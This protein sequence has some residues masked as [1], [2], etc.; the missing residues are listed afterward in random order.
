MATAQTSKILVAVHGIGPQVGYETVQSVAMRIAAYYGTAPAV[1]LGHFYPSSAT[2]GALLKPMPRLMQAPN[3]PET[4]VGLGFAEVYWAGIAKEPEAAGYVL[5]EAKKWAR[6]ISARLTLRAGQTGNRLP[7]REQLRLV[8]VLDQIIDTI[9]IFERLSYLPA[10]AGFFEFGLRRLLVDFVGDVQIVADFEAYRQRILDE[11]DRVMTQASQLSPEGAATELY[12]VAHSEGSVVAFLAL[13]TALASPDRHPWI[14]KVRGMLTIGSPIETHHLLWPE[15]WQKTGPDFAGL[16]PHPLAPRGIRWHNHFDRGD[17]IAYPL[18]DTR[19]WLEAQGFRPHLQ[20]EET[21]FSRFLLPGKAHTD[22]WHDE[23]VFGHFI[24]TI[25]KLPPPKTGAVR[26]FK[27]PPKNKPGVVVVSY[28]I[29]YALIMALLVAATYVLYRPASDI[30]VKGGLSSWTVVRDVIGMG[31]L[32][33]GITA[34]GRLPRLMQQKRWWLISAALLAVSMVCYSNVTCASSRR[35]LGWA[36]AERDLLTS[37]AESDVAKRWLS[38]ET[39]FEACDADMNSKEKAVDEGNLKGRPRDQVLASYSL[40]TRRAT[41]GVL[42]LSGL[43]SLIA[44]TAAIWSPYWGVRLLPSLGVVAAVALI[45][46]LLQA[47]D[48][49]ITL[50]PLVLGTAAFFYLWWLATL[51]FDLVFVWQRYIRHSA[52]RVQVSELSRHGYRATPLERAILKHTTR[53]NTR[54]ARRGETPPTES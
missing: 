4:L 3:D 24:E 6:T 23:A 14:Q 2:Q 46:S 1:P 54:R 42:M 13:L 37:A 51:L 20:L 49:T 10:K 33:F 12:I 45:V 22:Y 32:L 28:T 48:V 41:L 21:A 30:M 36:F 40:E 31:L 35:A 50:W 43:L 11:F 19:A 39:V 8:T 38:G 5:E 26:S 53:R 27:S 52:A 47:S 16:R 9:F 15:L 34:A 25:V 18:V 17:P 44:G 7:A 29:P